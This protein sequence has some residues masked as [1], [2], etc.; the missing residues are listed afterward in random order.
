MNFC[1]VILNLM[2][3]STKDWRSRNRKNV[4]LQEN[5]MSNNRNSTKN[6]E[7]NKD[8]FDV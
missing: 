3:R 8:S 7:N 6:P 1:K 5:D 4:V 2:N